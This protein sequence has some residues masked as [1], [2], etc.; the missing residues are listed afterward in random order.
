MD[1]GVAYAAQTRKQGHKNGSDSAAIPQLPDDVNSQAMAQRPMNCACS[2]SRTCICLITRRSYDNLPSWAAAL[3]KVLPFVQHGGRAAACL[4]SATVLQVK[5]FRMLMMS[6]RLQRAGHTFRLIASICRPLKKSKS[7]LLAIFSSELLSKPSP[8]NTKHG[9]ITAQQ[10][11]A[12]I[13]AGYC[14]A[15]LT[16]IEHA[17]S[18][19]HAAAQDLTIQ[20]FVWQQHLFHNMMPATSS[21]P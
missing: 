20:T 7:R 1:A 16:T 6:R 17:Q 15:C 19:G 8:T 3:F 18:F 4:P 13:L 11:S 21:H 10:T 14:T 5:G 12:W 9:Y 2:Y